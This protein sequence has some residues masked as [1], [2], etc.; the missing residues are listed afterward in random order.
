VRCARPPSA[1]ARAVVADAGALVGPQHTCFSLVAITA[2]GLWLLSDTLGCVERLSNRLA[3]DLVGFL[4]G[5]VGVSRKHVEVLVVG[6]W[7]LRR[8]W[9]AVCLSLSV[10]TKLF[11]NLAGLLSRTGI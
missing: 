6:K 8:V 2:I 4:V 3:R 1:V 10:D 5:K 7:G 11:V 9:A